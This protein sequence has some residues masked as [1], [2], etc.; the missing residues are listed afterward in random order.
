MFCYLLIYEAAAI[1]LDRRDTPKHE[2]YLDDGDAGR[3]VEL[4]HEQLTEEDARKYQPISQG[5]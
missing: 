4:V 2:P 3:Q 1:I 5:G